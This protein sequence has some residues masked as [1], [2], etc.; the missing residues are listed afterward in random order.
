MKAEMYGVVGRTYADLG[1]D[2]PASEYAKLQ[3]ATLRVQGADT[4][5]I[6]RALMLLAEVSLT[7]ERYR[8]AEEHS[9]PRCGVTAAGRC[10]TLRGP[11]LACSSAGANREVGRSEEVCR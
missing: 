7:A 11:G 2:R 9:R 5:H 4:Q 10:T 8:D 3:L 1:V 6:A